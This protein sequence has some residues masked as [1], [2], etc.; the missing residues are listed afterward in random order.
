MKIFKILSLT[1]V[2]AF[3]FS[4]CD[5]VEAPYQTGFDCESRKK[6]EQIC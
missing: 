4:A 3:V 5:K 2:I 6:N 1:L